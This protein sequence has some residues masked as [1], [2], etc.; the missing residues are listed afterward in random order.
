[1]PEVVLNYG[2]GKTP[3]AL[4]GIAKYFD[5]VVR[6]PKPKKKASVNRTDLPIV[7]AE[8]P[9]FTALAGIGKDKKISQQDLLKK[10]WSNSA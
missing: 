4:K 1:M 7:F 6:E 5:F 8:Y 10:A 9:D 3:E 2:S